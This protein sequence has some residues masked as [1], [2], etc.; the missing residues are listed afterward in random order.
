MAAKKAWKRNENKKNEMKYKK[1]L[2]VRGR[3]VNGSEKSHHKDDKK[4]LKSM[5]QNLKNDKAIVL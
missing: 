3:G 5:N 4:K 2:C 1:N